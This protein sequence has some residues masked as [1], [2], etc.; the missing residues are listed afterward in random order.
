MFAVPDTFLAQ[1]S[2]ADSRERLDWVAALPR[3]VTRAAE[4]W[5]L[6]PDGPALHGFV[7]VVWPVRL[8]DGTRAML[9]VSWPHDEE[10]DE[11]TALATWAGDGAVRLLADDPADHALLLERL[12][13]HHCLDEVPIAEAVAVA[14]GL[15]R[16]LAVPAPPLTRT[17]P[18]LAARWA[19]ELPEEAA[20]LGDPVPARLLGQAVAHCRE[21]GPAAAS[22]LVNEDLHYQN[23]LRADREP[24]LAIDPKPI[25]GDPEF[26][27]IALVWN[28]WEET[29]GVAG[30]ADRVAAVVDAAGL[31][32]ERARAWTF[33]RAVD[34]WLW[35]L[36]DRG[37]RMAEVCGDIAR[38]LAAPPVL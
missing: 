31:D 5:S 14:G 3:L 13:P 15:L 25:A 35:A 1:F 33:T 24:W 9:K 17:L 18:G 22:L 23:V 36:A 30:L 37:Y 26:A 28:R 12:D 6:T 11:G 10:V 7:G 34:T 21:L 19:R 38:G 16:R 2:G 20:G 32:V 4:R 8:P 29:G 27:A